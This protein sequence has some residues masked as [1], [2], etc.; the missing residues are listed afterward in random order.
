[1]YVVFRTRRL[2]KCYLLAE[3]GE[4]EWGRHVARRYIE[5]VNLLRAVARIDDLRTFPSLHVHPLKGQRKGQYAIDL[6]R[7]HRLIFTLEGSD[8]ETVRIEEVSKH[9]ED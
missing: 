3:A 8:P 4:G 1:M 5:R 7:R 2:E 9:Y 6:T